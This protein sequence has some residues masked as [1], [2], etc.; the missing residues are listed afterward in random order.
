MRDMGLPNG[1]YFSL[2]LFFS[3]MAHSAG[4][5]KSD[6]SFQGDEQ[7]QL[8]GDYFPS[9]AKELLPQEL[10]R[11][12]SIPTVQG[13]LL[14]SASAGSLGQK[15][16][17]WTYSGMAFRMLVDMGLHLNDLGGFTFC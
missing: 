7:F 2:F 4:F 10:E 12:G 13:L 9:R 16:Q 17:A 15:S 6:T 1:R 5:C 8:A 14:L 3:I 11:P